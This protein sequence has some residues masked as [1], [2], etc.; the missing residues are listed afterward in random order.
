MLR[1]KYWYVGVYAVLYTCA[2]KYMLRL[3]VVVCCVL[4]VVCVVLCV[5]CVLCVVCGTPSHFIFCKAMRYDKI[6][7]STL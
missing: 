2:G 4:C 1:V 7:G 5:L 6:C 3:P